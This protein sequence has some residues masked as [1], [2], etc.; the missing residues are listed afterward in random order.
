[1]TTPAINLGAQAPRDMERRRFIEC[2]TCAAAA[3]L[4]GCASL[5]TR[6]VEPVN[7]VIRLDIGKYPELS[8]PGGSVKIQPVGQTEPL[9]VLAVAGAGARPE[10][11]VLSPRCTHQGC[12]VEVQGQY[13]VC[14]CH[15]S[16]YDRRGMVL[17]GPAERALSA[18]P[19]VF[20]DG[21]LEIRLGRGVTP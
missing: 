15:G 1:M 4:T 7:G 18:A 20:A 3:L 2:V 8:R 12:T 5:A 11:S 9:L 14:P 17:R 6:R 19:S 16:T 13:L 10:Y 21:V